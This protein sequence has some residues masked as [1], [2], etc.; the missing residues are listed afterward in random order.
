MSA[1]LMDVANG[2]GLR[3]NKL[4]TNDYCHGAHCK[5]ARLAPMIIT[6]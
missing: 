6:S 2:A 3:G 4:R 5:E 1:D